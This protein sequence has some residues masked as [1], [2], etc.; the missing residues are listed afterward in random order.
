MLNALH[1]SW[2]AFKLH[3]FF[4]LMKLPFCPKHVMKIWGNQT[5]FNK[6][7]PSRFQ[8]YIY[9]I[10]SQHHFKSQSGVV[11]VHWQQFLHWKF[12]PRKK[13]VTRFFFLCLGKATWIKQHHWGSVKKIRDSFAYEFRADSRVAP[14]QWETALLC[15]DV[16]HWLDA[17]LESTLWVA[18]LLHWP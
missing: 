11:S 15:N 7:L 13:I 12:P 10:I 17:S 1:D 14:S 8:I 9:S 4:Y 5:M 18:P 16:S 2:M 6:S 3:T